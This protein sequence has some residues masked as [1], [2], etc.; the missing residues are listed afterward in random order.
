MKTRFNRDFASVAAAGVAAAMLLFAASGAQAL[1][2]SDT[3]SFTNTA[4]NPVEAP[5]TTDNSVFN[6][7]ATFLSENGRSLVATGLR[8]R[9]KGTGTDFTAAAWGDGEGAGPLGDSMIF[10]AANPGPLGTAGIGVC[11]ASDTTGGCDARPGADQASIGDS[12]ANDG[13]EGEVLR[14]AL[15]SGDLTFAWV[16]VSLTL[17]KV[18]GQEEV[19]IFFGVNDDFRQAQLLEACTISGVPGQACAGEILFL[20][21]QT[22]GCVGPCT[23]QSFIINFDEDAPPARFLFVTARID[24]DAECTEVLNPGAKNTC[25]GLRKDAF[26]VKEF[27]G[28]RVFV[29]EPSSIAVLASALFGLVFVARRRR[30]RAA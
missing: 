19:E 18:D 1:T 22:G 8:N 9:A 20:A 26:L 29:P 7:K 11:F 12:I 13:D 28:A 30:S 21:N 14:L 6:P 2:A 15:P 16:P 3:W 17:S 27:A 5:Y 4:G 25:L 24:D 10:Q 23:D